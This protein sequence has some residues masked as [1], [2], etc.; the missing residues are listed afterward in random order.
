V[1]RAFA[2]DHWSFVPSLGTFHISVIRERLGWS[3]RFLGLEWK[4]CSALS[5]ATWQERSS[6]RCRSVVLSVHGVAIA[7]LSWGA[8]SEI[9]LAQWAVASNPPSGWPVR[10]ACMLRFSWLDQMLPPGRGFWGVSGNG[11]ACSRP[12]RAWEIVS[13]TLSRGQPV[14]WLG[15]QYR[16]LLYGWHLRAESVAKSG[17]LLAG[18]T[19]SGGSKAFESAGCYT[20]S[21]WSDLGKLW[22]IMQACPS[23]PEAGE[24]T[25]TPEDGRVRPK[26][27][28]G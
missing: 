19:F 24:Y 25:I 20:Y 15:C 17:F 2:S 26:H 16:A 21:G 8:T 11:M 18:E 6:I 12:S 9:Q 5:S 10:M 22:L 23:P 14:H 4:Y 27:V 7:G 1:I 3:R 28:D 13:A